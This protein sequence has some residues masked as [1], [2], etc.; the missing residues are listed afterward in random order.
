MVLNVTVTS[1]DA[2]SWLTVW[3]DGSP[4]PA[5]S[6]LNYTS[7]ETVPNRVIATVPADGLVDL[8]V[9]RG[10]TEV[11][12]DVTGYFTDTG[13]GGE[14][15]P[16]AQPARLVDTRP[17]VPPVSPYAGMTVA[18]GTPLPVAG[19]GVDGVPADATALA[20]NV[21]V[22]NPSATS[23]LTVWPGGPDPGTSDLNFVPGETV[24]NFDVVTLSTGA[25]LP[26]GSFDV[27]PFA[28]TTDVVVDVAGWFVPAPA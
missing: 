28:G 27:A 23:W 18:A 16:A 21:T 19:T 2:G 24:P 22:T 7:G 12:A 9:A 4:E 5:T 14:F 10:H 26:T 15:E 11:V 6:T 13:T 8:V 17:N 3:P 1:P 25:E 20:A